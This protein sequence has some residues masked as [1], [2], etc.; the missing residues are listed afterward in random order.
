MMPE[1]KTMYTVATL[2]EQLK[3]YNP[4]ATVRTM[5]NG[6]DQYLSMTGSGQDNV[7]LLFRPLDEFEVK[8]NV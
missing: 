6:E 5:V 7:L 8:P 3:W 2:I 1:G 4:N